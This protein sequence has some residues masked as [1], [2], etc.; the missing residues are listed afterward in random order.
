MIL[1]TTA[2]NSVL[3]DHKGQGR[4]PARKVPGPSSEDLAVPG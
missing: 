1:G 4:G 2:S 3:L